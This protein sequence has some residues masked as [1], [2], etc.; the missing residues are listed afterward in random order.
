MGTTWCNRKTIMKGSGRYHEIGWNVGKPRRARPGSGII[1]TAMEG[2][3][4]NRRL[5][6]G[7]LWANMRSEI[8]STFTRDKC[9]YQGYTR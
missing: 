5:S 6:T 7:M 3:A 4:D 2:C 8:A 9:I 1:G